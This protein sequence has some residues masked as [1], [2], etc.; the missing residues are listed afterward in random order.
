VTI[1]SR[2]RRV[3]RKGGKY[4]K[5]LKQHMLWLLPYFTLHY[6][7]ESHLLGSRHQYT[8]VFDYKHIFDYF[9]Y[10]KKWYSGWKP[11]EICKRKFNHYTEEGNEMGSFGYICGS[12]N[13]NDLK[14]KR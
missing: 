3:R 14:N 9:W 4:M 10:I 2:F 8:L 6:K 7:R 5:E 1:T 13:F 11:C 12:C